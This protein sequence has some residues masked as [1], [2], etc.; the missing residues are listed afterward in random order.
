MIGI[1]SVWKL[2]W[3]LKIVVIF[4]ILNCESCR[5]SWV[6]YFMWSKSEEWFIHCLWVC[7]LRWRWCW[8]SLVT[9]YWGQLVPGLLWSWQPPSQGYCPAPNWELATIHLHPSDIVNSLPRLQVSPGVSSKLIHSGPLISQPTYSS[10]RITR[11]ALTF[12]VFYYKVYF[13]YNLNVIPHPEWRSLQKLPPSP[14]S[15]PPSLQVSTV[16]TIMPLPACL[17]IKL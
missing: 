16:V 8:C 12:Y 6:K 15:L 4:Q 13:Y 10:S 7:S 17:T 14:P 11:A 9:I 2:A 3:F 1:F 5:C